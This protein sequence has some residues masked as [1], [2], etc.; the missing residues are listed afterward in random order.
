MFCVQMVKK[1]GTNRRQ[2]EVYSNIHDI[3]AEAHTAI[4]NCLVSVCLLKSRDFYVYS[5][6]PGVTASETATQSLADKP[7]HVQLIA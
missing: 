1:N 6:Y 7:Y 5:V 4:Y 3:A 2:C